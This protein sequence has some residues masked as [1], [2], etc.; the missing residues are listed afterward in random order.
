MYITLLP[1][2]LVLSRWKYSVAAIPAIR[3]GV[4]T[5]WNDHS[6]F[7][8]VIFR[9]CMEI[10]NN[11]ITEG[12]DPDL[13]LKFSVD[14]V[15]HPDI[16]LPKFWKRVGVDCGVGLSLAPRQEG[17]DYT[18]LRDIK[19]AARAIAVECVI[20]PP[21]AG[22]FIPLGWHDK[23]GVLISGPRTPSIRQNSTRSDE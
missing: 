9:E 17:Y 6:R 7:Q 23:L 5:C 22:G 12:Y 11:D 15:Y 16:E 18:R 10:I 3:A 4:P 1:F 13:P 14:P 20:R 21:H 8:P 2:L 19:D